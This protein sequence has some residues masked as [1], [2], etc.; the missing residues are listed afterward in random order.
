MNILRMIK[1]FGVEA[2][3]NGV[4]TLGLVN[5]ASLDDFTANNNAI[6]IGKTK[7][8]TFETSVYPDLK[9]SSIIV[10]QGVEYK[11]IDRKT[12]GDS[13]LTTVYLQIVK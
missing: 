13:V 12:S 3:F 6:V 4:S 7:S 11:V 2:S 8:F 10:V 9:V 1:P 5:V